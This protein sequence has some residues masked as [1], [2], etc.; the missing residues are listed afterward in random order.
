MRPPEARAPLLEVDGISVRFGA[1]QALQGVSLT[2]G[3][4]EIAAIIGPN[5]AGKTSL[6]NVIS[7]FY[8]PSEG[9]IRFD[10]KDR[11]LPIEPGQWAVDGKRPTDTL[12]DLALGRG[13][14]RSP[15]EI[16]AGAVSLIEGMLRSAA[17]GAAVE[18]YS[19]EEA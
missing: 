14:N 9:H 18:V 1:V 5:G 7:G 11:T 17:E 15:G 2:I 4:G 6:L 10:G 13:E 19:P 12:V 3:R 8:R 16:G